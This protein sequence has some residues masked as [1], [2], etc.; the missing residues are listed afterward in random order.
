MLRSR[1]L[2][3]LHCR[4][5]LTLDELAERTGLSRYQIHRAIKEYRRERGEI[6]LSDRKLRKYRKQGLT[7]R[8]IADREMCSKSVI[9]KRCHRLG[10]CG[11]RT[12]AEE[13]GLP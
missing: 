9:A 5:G 13:E 3:Y 10:L 6:I 12:K 4:R 8:Q 11:A 7:V 1:D 2:Y